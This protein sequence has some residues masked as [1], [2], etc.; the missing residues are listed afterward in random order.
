M[1]ATSRQ[2]GIATLVLGVAL[3]AS[4]NSTPVGSGPVLC[5]GVTRDA[6]GCTT[7]R[8][9]FTGSTCDDLAREWGMFVD[10]LVVTIVTGPDDAGGQG[11]SVRMKQ[12]V[13]ITTGDM[14]ERMRELSLRA[15]CDVGGVLAVAE[16]E[17]S[18]TLRGSVGGA[19]FDGDPAVGYDDWITDVRRS[20]QV[21][22]DED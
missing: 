8:H 5:D 1:A 6:G 16:R 11:K 15:E 13:V 17:F 20:L 18:E 22:D 7:E 3:S 21:I 10:R 19:M 12:A 4:C 14:N 9:E 2:L